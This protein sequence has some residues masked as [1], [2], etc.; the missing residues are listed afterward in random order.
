MRRGGLPN[1]SFAGYEIMLVRYVDGR[2]PMP[3]L[4]SGWIDS[5]AL[6]RFDYVLLR[7]GAPVPITR[8]QVLHLVA[9]DGE[10]MLFAVCGS[11]ALPVCG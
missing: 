11:E 5:P 9:R 1:A 4:G 6:R 8:K 10:W 3:G 2:N 7:E